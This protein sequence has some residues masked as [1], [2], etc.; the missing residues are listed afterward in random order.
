MSTKYDYA[1]HTINKGYFSIGN[2]IILQDKAPGLIKRIIAWYV[3]KAR[4]CNFL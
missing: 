4:W 2:K 1:T 3:L